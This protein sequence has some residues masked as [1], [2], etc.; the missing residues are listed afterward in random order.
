MAEA[1][2]LTGSSRSFLL[3]P[4][5]WALLASILIVVCATAYFDPNH[6]YVH[7]WDVVL[8]DNFRNIAPVG[9]LALGAARRRRFPPGSRAPGA[10]R[11]S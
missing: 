11:R 1:R 3:R 5:E 8:K 10:W 4:Q 7:S 9:M 6:A 2:T